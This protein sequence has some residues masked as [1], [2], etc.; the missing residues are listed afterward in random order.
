MCATM[1]QVLTWPTDEE[2]EEAG[3]SG[4]GIGEPEAEGEA[5]AGAEE[6]AGGT[7]RSGTLSAFLSFS[8]AGAREESAPAIVWAES[9]LSLLDCRM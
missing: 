3:E 7:A 2:G 1:P 6:E 9:S 8:M 5:E 4:K